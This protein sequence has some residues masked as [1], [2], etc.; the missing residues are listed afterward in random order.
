MPCMEKERRCKICDPLISIERCRLYATVKLCG[1]A[2][3]R[4]ENSR[5]LHNRAAMRYQR[6]Q[7]AE[8][9]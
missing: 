9:R 3:C 6:R 1:G 2:E 4:E 8:A 5:R 7:R